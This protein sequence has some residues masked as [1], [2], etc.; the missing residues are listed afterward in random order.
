MEKGGKMAAEQKV[1]WD[2]TRDAMRNNAQT[3]KSDV[4]NSFV[5]QYFKGLKEEVSQLKQQFNEEQQQ[6]PPKTK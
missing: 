6:Q 1:T 4:N 2:A 5:A 3:M